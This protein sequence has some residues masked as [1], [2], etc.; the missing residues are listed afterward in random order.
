MN[1]T[2]KKRTPCHLLDCNP[3]CIA[4]GDTPSCGDGSWGF[5]G[6][7]HIHRCRESDPQC[8]HDVVLCEKHQP[9]ELAEMLRDEVKALRITR[10]VKNVEVDRLTNERTALETALAA[11]TAERD[12]RDV[13]IGVLGQAIA[14]VKSTTD[15][16]E[17]TNTMQAGLFC[18]VEDRDLR[19]RYDGARYGYED[20]LERCEEFIRNAVSAVDANHL[21]R[22]AVEGER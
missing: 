5:M 14:N 6:G 20:A 7:F 22:A 8:G 19:D 4:C 11:M 12:A 13:A 17:L 3:Q 21:A 16:P 9:E 10:D 15:W 1:N 2:K 18:G